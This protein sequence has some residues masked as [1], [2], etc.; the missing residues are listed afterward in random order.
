MRPRLATVAQKG[1][2]GVIPGP[3]ANFIAICAAQDQVIHVFEG[4][5]SIPFVGGE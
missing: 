1:R 2:I 4:M 3:T 5:E